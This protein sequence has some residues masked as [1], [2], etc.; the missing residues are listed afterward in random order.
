MN[1]PSLARITFSRWSTPE[2]SMVNIASRVGSDG[3]GKYYSRPSRRAHVARAILFYDP[4]I[5]QSGIAD[6]VLTILWSNRLPVKSFY[7]F[8]S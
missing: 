8:K 4:A 1:I 2:W 7:M 5:K 3:S 6:G